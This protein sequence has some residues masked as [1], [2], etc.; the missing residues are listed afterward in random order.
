M[1]NEKLKKILQQINDYNQQKHNEETLQRIYMLEKTINEEENKELDEYNNY[2]DLLEQLKKLEKELTTARY[3]KEKILNLINKENQYIK[4]NEDRKQLINKNTKNYD[5][6]CELKKELSETKKEYK[7]IELEFNKQKQQIYEEDIKIKELR[8]KC[9]IA[10]D[11]I[12]KCGESVEDIKDYELLL[13]ILKNNGLCDK[14][15]KDQII[16]DL[17]KSIDEICS[18]IGHEKIYINIENSSTNQ[19]KKYNIIIR[20]DK[21]KDIA[22]AGGFQKNIMELIFK[23]AFLRIN[24]YL[25]SDFI[26]ID[27]LFDACS[28]ENKPM[29]IKL[30]EYFKTQYNKILLVSHNQS[31]INLFDKRLIIER[32]NIYGNKIKFN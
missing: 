32:D 1:Y 20:T 12:N 14:L 3:N 17:Q 2:C 25:H 23:L 30:V 16:V 24:T 11:I 27:E 8:N 26:I 22:N 29:A 18:Y 15:L 31:I 5:I 13:N 21:I 7:T 28:E 10:K 4:E 19:K 9:I 6:Y